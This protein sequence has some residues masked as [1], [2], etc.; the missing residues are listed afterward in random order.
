M[1][2]NFMAFNFSTS[3]KLKAIKFC[4][5]FDHFVDIRDINLVAWIA[6]GS[7]DP[8]R[9]SVIIKDTSS[10]VSKIFIDATR[11]SKKDGF[12]R[13]WPN[14]V[15]MDLKTIDT[16]DKKWVKLSLGDFVPSP[17]L[18]YRKLNQSEGDK[19]IEQ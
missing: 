9:D 17:S 8:K 5:I 16:V 15:V 11:K 14:V 18:K 19:V 12:E 4:I 10:S 3:E 1:I 13:D 6:S 7:I 2:Q